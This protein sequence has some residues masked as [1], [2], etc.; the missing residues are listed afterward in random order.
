M[1]LLE[2]GGGFE[3]YL[4]EHATGDPS[5]AQ[6]RRGGEREPV[7]ARPPLPGG[8][9]V[10]PRRHLLSLHGARGPLGL[11]VRGAD[12]P[13]ARGDRAPANVVVLDTSRYAVSAGTFPSYFLKR[14]DAVALAQMRVDL[15]LFA[16]RIAPAFFGEGSFRRS[17]AVRCH[18]RGLQPGDAGGVAA[19]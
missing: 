9:G 18:H 2:Y 10:P 13:G 15:R 3:S 19:T 1:T 6:W 16:S 4:A 12:P 17:R 8:D 5:G 14:L 7:H 11:P